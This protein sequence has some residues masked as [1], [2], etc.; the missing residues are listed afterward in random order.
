MKEEDSLETASYQINDQMDQLHSKESAENPEEAFGRVVAH[1]LKCA[2]SEIKEDLKLGI[3]V[4]CYHAIKHG[5][6]PSFDLSTNSL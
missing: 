6:V 1:W 4:I 5:S 2:S 3:H